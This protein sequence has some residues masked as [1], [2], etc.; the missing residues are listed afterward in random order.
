MTE[1]SPNQSVEPTG[2]RHSGCDVTG[3][4]TFFFFFGWSHSL[5][6]VAHFYR[7]PPNTKS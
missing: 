1:S 3:N 6:P 7:S 5:A 2:A 4:S